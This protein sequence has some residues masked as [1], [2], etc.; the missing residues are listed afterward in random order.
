MLEPER[1]DR[2]GEPVVALV[3][4]TVSPWQ[5][6][7]HQSNVVD[8]RITMRWLAYERLD[9]LLGTVLFTLGAVAV[10]AAC[11]F[12]FDGTAAHGAFVDA[13][14]LEHALARRAGRRPPPSSRS[15]S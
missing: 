13:G 8:K 3:G 5:L 9:T 14:A 10:V 11:A 12:A 1:A 7:F 4:A 15:C 2:P 6:F